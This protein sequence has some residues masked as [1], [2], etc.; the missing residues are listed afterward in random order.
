MARELKH[1]DIGDNPKLLQIIEEAHAGSE[2][3]VLC[4]ENEDVAIL[5]PVKRAARRRNFKGRPTST[6]DP[7]WTIISSAEGPDDGVRDV[8]ANK[9]GYLSDAYAATHE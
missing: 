4:R 3:L 6:N 7:F 1:I 2:S 9:H 5:Q 8:S